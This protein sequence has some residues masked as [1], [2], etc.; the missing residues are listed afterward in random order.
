MSFRP[1]PFMGYDIIPF[2][3]FFQEIVGGGVETANERNS[4]AVKK[5]LIEDYS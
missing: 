2:S 4:V 3:E 5:R 1:D